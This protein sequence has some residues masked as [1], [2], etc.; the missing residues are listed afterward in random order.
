WMDHPDNQTWYLNNLWAKFPEWTQNYS[1]YKDYAYQE[2]QILS[3]T[4]RSRRLFHPKR[5]NRPYI[6]YRNGNK[7]YFCQLL[8]MIA[9]LYKISFVKRKILLNEKKTPAKK[10]PY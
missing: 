10:V 3:Y 8:Q 4:L 9:M 7:E 2:F 1:N 5:S 6:H